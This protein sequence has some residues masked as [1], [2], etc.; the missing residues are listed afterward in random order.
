MSRRGLLEHKL[1]EM[2]SR[3]EKALIPYICGGDPGLEETVRLVPALALAGADVVEIGIPFSD[4]VADGPVIQKAAARAL[5]AGTTTAKIIDAV[6]EI[7]RHTDVPIVLMSYYNP[8]HSFG[9]ERFADI[10]SSAGVDG[11]IV[12]DLPLEESGPLRQ[13][14]A[15]CGMAVLP[16]VAPNSGQERL[17]AITAAASGFIYCVS[18]K[19]V[20]GVRQEI[21][22]DI[23][24]FISCVRSHTK[25]PLAVGFGISGPEQAA[26]MAAFC[27]AVVVGSALV[28]I[29]SDKGNSPD[30]IPAVAGRVRELKQA[31][32]GLGGFANAAI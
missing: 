18:V 16:L 3:G 23:A 27:D 24:K 13:A 32:N 5:A 20:T 26:R 12:P 10:A 30:L 15:G 4:P 9:V 31:L 22:T 8:I 1:M 29:I 11:V 14:A 17:A 28:E 2:Q 6:A 21:D 25:L 7:R 19:G